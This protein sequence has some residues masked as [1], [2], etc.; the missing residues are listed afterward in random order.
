MACVHF[1]YKQDDQLVSPL[2]SGLVL[3]S[4]ANG[5]GDTGALSARNIDQLGI[6]HVLYDKMFITTIGEP[7]AT[8]VGASGN[9]S[10]HVHIKVPMKYAKKKVQFKA[11]TQY[12]TNGIYM[13]ITT[14]RAGVTINPTL[15]Y[16]FSVS[17]TDS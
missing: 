3:A 17:Y 13:M 4:N 7:S 14:D 2:L 16:N 10:R 8:S 1:Q 11:G 6:Y 9:E 5:G 15:A 12:C